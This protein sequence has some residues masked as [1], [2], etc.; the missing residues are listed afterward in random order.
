MAAINMKKIAHMQLQ[1][2]PLIFIFNKQFVGHNAENG[3]KKYFNAK[4]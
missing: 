1:I 4:Q 3:I 2:F